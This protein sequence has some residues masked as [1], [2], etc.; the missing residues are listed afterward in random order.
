MNDIASVTIALQQAIF[1]D[2]YEDLRT[3]GAFVLIDETTH[4]TVAAGM[5]E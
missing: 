1:A 2:A 3:T 4:Q 5:I